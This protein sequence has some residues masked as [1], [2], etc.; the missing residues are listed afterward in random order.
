[1]N[2]VFQVGALVA[3]SAGQTFL[4]F[5]VVINIHRWVFLDKALHAFVSR[6]MTGLVQVAYLLRFRNRVCVQ[7]N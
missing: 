4:G 2:S 7:R 6:A 1:M 5:H 3:I